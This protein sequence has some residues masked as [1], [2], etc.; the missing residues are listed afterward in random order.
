MERQKAEVA[1]QLFELGAIKFGTF[2]LKLHETQPEAPQSPIYLTLRTANHPTN[3]GPL[4]D[5]VVEMIVGL[6]INQIAEERI[7][8]DCFVGIPEAG[9]PFADVLER[10]IGY[11]VNP[12]QRLRLEKEQLES[13]K[14]RIGMAVTGNFKPGDRVLVID[15]LITQADSKLEAIKALEAQ[16]L[17]IVYVLVLVDRMQ[18]GKEQLEEQGHKL[19]AIFTLDELLSFYVYEDY[20]PVG[21]A[22]E[23]LKYVADNRR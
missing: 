18:G 23:V 14:R 21:R 19:V 8:Y 1:R 6:M 15:D 13:G 10:I 12:P 17:V 4:T 3:P 9:E 22:D 20:I 5:E 2:R 16:G 11:N 7:G